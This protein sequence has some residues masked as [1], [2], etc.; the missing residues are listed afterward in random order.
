MGRYE[1]DFLE[2]YTDQ[3][4]LAE[5]RRIAAQIPP[6]TPLTI[7]AFEDRSPKVSLCRDC[8]LGKGRTSIR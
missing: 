5:V 4:L 8:N 3:A 7:A 6:G 2:E 1:I